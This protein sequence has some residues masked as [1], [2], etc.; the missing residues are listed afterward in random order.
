MKILKASDA[1]AL[2]NPKVAEPA[3]GEEVKEEQSEEE[4]DEGDD[5]GDGKKEMLAFDPAKLIAAEVIDL[6]NGTYEVKYKVDTEEPVKIWVYYQTED[7]QYEEIRG[8]PF[9]AEFSKIAP[10][11]NG[12][13][14]GKSLNEYITSNLTNISN[15]LSSTKTAVFI[16]DMENW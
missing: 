13:M 10:P 1:D 12:S 3:E 7:E 6:D 8:S 14:E 16:K 2:L 9:T 4:D 11:K 5:G 15:Y